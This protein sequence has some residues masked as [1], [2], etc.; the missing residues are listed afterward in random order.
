MRSSRKKAAT[1]LAL[2]HDDPRRRRRELHVRLLTVE[3]LVRAAGHRP[4]RRPAWLRL[5]RRDRASVRRGRRRHRS[6]SAAGSR[7]RHVC[8]RARHR[9]DGR[10]GRGRVGSCAIPWLHL[11]GLVVVRARPAQR[12][13]QVRVRRQI[14]GGRAHA[15]VVLEAERDEA[16]RVGVEDLI[17]RRRL[18]L[19]RRRRRQRGVRAG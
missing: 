15:V 10:R 7:G 12:R 17:E 1:R 5:R 13:R 6:S 2:R 8:C 14:I 18:G 4:R 19:L 16:A 9:R 3:Q 11:D